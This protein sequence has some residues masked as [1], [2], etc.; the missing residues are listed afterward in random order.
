MALSTP[1]GSTR[2]AQMA[3]RPNL[4]GPSAIHGEGMEQLWSPA[5]ATGSN[6]WQMRHPQKPLKQADPQTGGNLTGTVPERMVG[7][8]RRESVRGLHESQQLAFFVALVGG[9]RSI[10]V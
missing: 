9:Q 5:G 6:R 4:L 10:H 7:G 3:R 8:G 2:D 1:K